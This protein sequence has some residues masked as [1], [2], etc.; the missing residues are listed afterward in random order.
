MTHY[1]EKLIKKIYSNNCD[2]FENILDKYKHPEIIK[3]T[4]STDNYYSTPLYKKDLEHL[5]LDIIV[6][7]NLQSI[8]HK[9]NTRNT[10]NTRNVINTNAKRT[11]SEK[12]E[13]VHVQNKDELDNKIGSVSNLI[14]LIT[15]KIDADTRN[16]AL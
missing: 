4:F 12:N 9:I 13:Y 2:L 3:A 15:K 16:T 8:K 10:I 1:M 5:E 6:D 7:E 14:S 11:K